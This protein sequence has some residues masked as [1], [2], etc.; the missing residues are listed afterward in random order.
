MKNKKLTDSVL[1]R[2]EKEKIKPIK[3]DIFVLKNTALF[4]LCG[5][6]ILIG[7]V[8]FAMNL[9]FLSRLDWSVIT[10]VQGIMKFVLFTPPFLWLLL[11]VVSIF[12]MYIEFRKTKDGY[13]MENKHLIMIIAALVLISG[14]IG[15]GIE[16]KY[17]ITSY[18]TNVAAIRDA[19]DPR[20]KIW[21]NPEDGL[22][23]GEIKEVINDELLIVDL[24]GMDWEINIKDA[25]IA[26]K[27]VL[28]ND[29]S[30]KIIGEKVSN[31]R[32]NASKI[33][34]WGQGKMRGMQENNSIYRNTK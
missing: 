5:I 2:I 34:P 25:F 8:G 30:I 18:F 27:V 23:A 24:E 32:F 22:L 4:V 3:K 10:Y 1:E 15:W 14:V 28:Q 21:S 9:T 17:N 7:G 29:E 19:T 16:N 20:Y 12:M 13:R 6:S 33:L 11:T 26:G 31:S